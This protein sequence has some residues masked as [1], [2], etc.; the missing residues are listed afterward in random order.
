MK[1]PFRLTS[2]AGLITPLS[3]YVVSN[4][5][6][7]IDRYRPYLWVFGHTH[8]QT[9]LQMPGGPCCAMSRSAT[10]T[11]SGLAMSA[12]GSGAG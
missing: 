10:N 9:E 5:E 11:S 1:T 7:L 8:R 12:R 2:A 3:P 6:A 4:L